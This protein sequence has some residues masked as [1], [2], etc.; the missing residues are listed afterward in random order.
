MWLEKS[1]LATIMLQ[2]T[3]MSTIVNEVTGTTSTKTWIFEIFHSEFVYGIRQTCSIDG[4]VPKVD[5][6]GKV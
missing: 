4:A 3:E 2:S 1:I 5:F 6:I